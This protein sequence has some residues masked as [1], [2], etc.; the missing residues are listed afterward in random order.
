MHE[1]PAESTRRIA[2]LGFDGMQLLDV[3]GP[4]EVF[5]MASR[6]LCSAAAARAPAPAPAYEVMLVAREA[7]PVAGSSGL[8][9]AAA[10]SWRDLG[11]VDT[12]LVSGGAGARQAIDDAALAAWLAREAPL[13]RRFGSVCTGAL[14]LA[15]AGLLDGRRVTTHWGHVDALAQ[16]APSA[17]I[18]ADAIFIRDGRLWT[19]AGVTAGMDMALAMLEEDHGRELALDVARQ[20]VMYL[21]RPGGQSQYSAPLAA[22]S[23]GAERRFRG[24]VAWIVDHVDEDLS[25]SALAERSA[26]SPRHFSRCFREETGLT[27][28]RFVERVRFEAAQRLLAQDA[29]S[30]DRVA[31]LSGFHSAETLRRVFLRN[32]GMGP[33]AYRLH[34]QREAMLKA[35]ASS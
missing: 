8:S 11:T 35:R 10:C 20:L 15:N 33:A 16:L 6:L 23:V 31:C 27:P 1:S 25:V 32:A 17:L 24:L 3:T 7:G 26:M 30:V 21:K 13:V 9:L 5:S 14:L 12:L 34:L 4:L 29:H 18:D 19:S 28:A 2:M 22:Q